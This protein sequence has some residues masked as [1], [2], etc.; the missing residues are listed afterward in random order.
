MSKCLNNLYS[1]F[2]EMVTYSHSRINTFFQCKYKYKL[3][4]IDK[5]RTPFESIEAFMGSR[6]HEA[7][8][9]L[10]TA[11]QH[12]TTLTKEN[13]LKAYLER[14]TKRWK[15]SITIAKE[16][17]TPDDYKHHG[18]TTLMTYYD[19][20]VPFT[21]LITLG[22]ETRDIL[23][24]ADGKSY[25]IRIDRLAKDTD[26]N[27]YV[28]DYK[29]S[30]LAKSQSD[31][32]KDTQ[33]AMYALWVK[34]NH[35]DA[36]TVTLLWRFLTP[37]TEVTSVRTDEQLHILKQT[38]E[39]NIDTIESCTDYP[40]TIS[41]LCDYCEYKQQCPAWTNV[42][43]TKPTKKISLGRQQKLGDFF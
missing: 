30:R 13:L 26:N 20:Y 38:I 9:V 17:M 11:I 41:K 37:N 4:Y 21:K 19:Q 39:T 28:I 22:L 3:N 10:Y 24:L 43:T 27:Y 6:V 16:H 32:D 14:W 35:P 5:I 15:P 23:P 40:T 25:H 42:P 18:L 1:F 31:V 8:E 34:N 33:L 36:K 2:Q 12:G 7:L 29:T